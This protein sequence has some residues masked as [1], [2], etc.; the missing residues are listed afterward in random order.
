MSMIRELRN[1]VKDEFKGIDCPTGN[2]PSVERGFFSHISGTALASVAYHGAF[3]FGDPVFSRS[4]FD[5]SNIDFAGK[6][7]LSTEQIE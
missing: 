3:S 6:D 7:K 2:R 5:G 4:F 1:L